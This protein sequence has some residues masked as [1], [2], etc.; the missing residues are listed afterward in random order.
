MGTWKLI[1]IGAG[2]AGLAA[3]IYAGRSGLKTVIIE[4]N[5]PG[6]E[7]SIT[8]EIENY[9][10][11]EKISGPVLVERM[12]NQCTKFGAQTPMLTEI[13]KAFGA[14]PVFLHPAEMYTSLERGLLE[15]WF[16]D[17]DGATAFKLPE[18]TKYRT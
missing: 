5:T 12:I 4:K 7:A 6:G 9:P 14:V 16:F 10:G 2:P 15:G 8:P 17:W 3:G 13:V 1:I 18:V 11:F